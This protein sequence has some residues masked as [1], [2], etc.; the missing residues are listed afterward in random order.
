MYTERDKGMADP[1]SHSS[2]RI[3]ASASNVMASQVPRKRSLL[4]GRNEWRVHR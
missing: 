1:Q 4:C 2:E 3:S